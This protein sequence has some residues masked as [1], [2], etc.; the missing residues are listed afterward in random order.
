M[1]YI[2]YGDSHHRGHNSHH[3]YGIR[4]FTLIELTVTL[5]IILILSL[6]FLQNLTKFGRENAIESDV[7]SL[8]AFIQKM[9]LYAFSQKQTLTLSLASNGTQ[10]CSSSGVCIDLKN[11]FVATGN[12]TITDRGTISSGS[13]RIR[14]S[15][16]ASL[17]VAYSCIAI[18]TTRVRKG[19]WN[20][21]NCIAK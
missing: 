14:D 15:I 18:S 20:G 16:P 7:I 2:G 12:F 8:T 4:G 10:L 6:L 11:G 13:I 1:A 5:V 3:R 19:Q 9:R 17:N 21:A